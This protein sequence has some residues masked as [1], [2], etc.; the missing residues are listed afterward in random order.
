[1][2]LHS[3]WMYGFKLWRIAGL[4]INEHFV[5][6]AETQQTLSSETETENRRFS[7]RVCTFY[8][9]KGFLQKTY[10]YLDRSFPVSLLISLCCSP[11]ASCCH[12]HG[13]KNKE[14]NKNFPKWLHI[15]YTVALNCWRLQLSKMHMKFNMKVKCESL[16][17]HSQVEAACEAVRRLCPR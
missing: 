7:Y 4:K 3:C 2:E 13:S 10:L 17:H 9:Y 15:I 16:F 1:M 8:S 6:E 14:I 11:R 12:H 5:G